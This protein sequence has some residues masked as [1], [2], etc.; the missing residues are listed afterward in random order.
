MFTDHDR[1]TIAT[2][3]KSILKL[4]Y[5]PPTPGATIPGM[6]KIMLFQHIST[7]PNNTTQRKTP[8]LNRGS[9][10]K[11]GG[12]VLG[13]ISLIPHPRTISSK[14]HTQ[15]MKIL[16]FLLKLTKRLG[17]TSMDGVTNTPNVGNKIG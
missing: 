15:K 7:V 2:P 12:T 13:G 5:R 1:T 16:P 8:F 14:S 6:G 10:L 17:R 11:F 3:R 4:S 9:F